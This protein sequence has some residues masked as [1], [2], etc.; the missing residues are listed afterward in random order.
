V[1]SLLQPTS[2]APRAR[3]QFTLPA[4]LQSTIGNFHYNPEVFANFLDF[5]LVSVSEFEMALVF[6]S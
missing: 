3:E 6:A 4:N 1:K 2:L 5:W